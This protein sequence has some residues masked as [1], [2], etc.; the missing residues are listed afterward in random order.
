MKIAIRIILGMSLLLNIVL[1]A[2]GVLVGGKVSRSIGNII[3]ALSERR[4]AAFEA[5]KIE[6]ADIVFLGDSI[7]HEG[8]WGEY[9]PGKTVLNRGISGDTTHDIL[10]RLSAVTAL[11]PDKLFLMIGINDLNRS[12]P[13]DD[14]IGRY[15]NL[16]DRF[17]T[18][19]PQ[20]KIY[21]QAV[22][23]TNSD[24]VTPIN[25]S[26]VAELNAFLETESARRQFQY[27]D[28]N[29]VF[30]D[31]NGALR[32]DLS[33]DGIHLSG[34]GYSLWVDYIVTYVNEGG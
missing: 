7:T 26:D 14:I 15:K 18:E 3:E 13:V 23:P 19:M 1:I 33:N 30:S 24:W 6:K 5:S 27:I 4:I 29:T 22:L 12:W 28:I 32:R 31:S 8:M 21:V 20:T 10:D 34:K 25:L 9:F 17:E 16:F 2:G 11:Q